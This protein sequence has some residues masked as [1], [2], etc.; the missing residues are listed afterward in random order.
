MRA[1][2]SDNVDIYDSSHGK[3]T[4]IIRNFDIMD[5]KEIDQQRKI[6]MKVYMKRI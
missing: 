2:N 1:N 5:M 6:L 4:Q 3:L